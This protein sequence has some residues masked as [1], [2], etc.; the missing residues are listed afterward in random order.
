MSV[1]ILACAVFSW[2]FMTRKNMES[3]TTPKL[4]F[5]DEFNIRLKLEHSNYSYHNPTLLYP[6][7][8]LKHL[9]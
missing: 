2:E 7:I 1:V 8:H 6:H 9:N 4:R 5:G 3:D